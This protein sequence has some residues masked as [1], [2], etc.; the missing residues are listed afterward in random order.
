LLQFLEEASAESVIREW[1]VSHTTLE[2]VFLEV[3]K[4]HGFTYEDPDVEESH[5]EDEE[6][7]KHLLLKQKQKGQTS[8][9]FRA[10]IRK[11]LSLQSRQKGTNCCQIVTPILVMAILLILQL[12]IR[13]ELHGKI[14]TMQ[15]VPTVS[16]YNNYLFL[17][18][19]VPLAT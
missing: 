11:N 14:D 3:T 5:E 10:L 18:D 12:I 13:N 16:V 9:P 7:E 2:E 4:K 1:G 6:D 17:L 8:Y 15:L 19:L